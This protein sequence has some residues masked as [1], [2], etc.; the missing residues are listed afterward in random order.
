M[1]VQSIVVLMRRRAREVAHT[2]VSIASEHNCLPFYIVAHADADGITASA[3]I[4]RVLNAQKIMPIVVFTN[5][6][7]INEI[8][9]HGTINPVLRTPTDAKE[10]IWIF[11]DTGFN[12][13][14]VLEKLKKKIII[15]HHFCSEQHLKKAQTGTFNKSIS[16]ESWTLLLSPHL[17]GVAHN[18]CTAAFLAYLIAKNVREDREHGPLA[19]V[20]ALGDGIYGKE[21]TISGIAR[22]AVQESIEKNEIQIKRDLLVPGK[23]TLSIKNLLIEMNQMLEMGF[24]T[25]ALLSEMVSDLKIP[26]NEIEEN[27]WIDLLP[28]EKRNILSWIA[29]KRLKMGHDAGAVLGMVGEVYHLKKHRPGIHMHDCAEF[30]KLLNECGERALAHEAYHLCLQQTEE[31]YRN[32]V[33]KLYLR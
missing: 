7:E 12:S 19:V 30:G 5:S 29:K 6:T 32:L 26:K 13:L 28:K 11:L 9:Y 8:V 17:F 14:N 25:E 31:N 33:D 10:G 20:G 16:H 21:F 2:I 23:E 15:D 27:R 4:T 24:E 22:E 3:I 1:H 18:E